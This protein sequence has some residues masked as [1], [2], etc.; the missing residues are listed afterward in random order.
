MKRECY[1]QTTLLCLK[2]CISLFLQLK[3]ESTSLL[4]DCTEF[5]MGMKITLVLLTK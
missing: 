1:L 5:I 3:A 4:P 2:S